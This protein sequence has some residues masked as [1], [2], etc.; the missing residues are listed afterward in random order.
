M[1][2]PDFILIPEVPID[3]ERFLDILIK[4][5]QE[6]KHV[7]AVISEGARWSGG[8][9]VHAEKDEIEEFEHPRFGGAA[10]AL[11]A[12][13]KQ[14]LA[15]YI[16]TRNLNSLNP[17]YLYRSGAPNALDKHWASRL[18]ASAVRLLAEGLRQP[19]FLS[20][21]KRAGDYEIDKIALSTFAS[22]ADLHRFVDDR[23]YNSREF[24]ISELGR[25]YISSIVPEIP[26]EEAYLKFLRPKKDRQP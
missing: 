20:I 1:G 8:G 21:Q 11:K 2:E 26:P 17:S 6:Q 9:Y 23:F 10:E 7:I 15:K 22:M 25:N 5:Y 19:V 24:R 12:R 4:R 18:A 13:L 3:Y 14:D 16:P